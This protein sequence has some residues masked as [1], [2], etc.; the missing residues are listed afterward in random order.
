MMKNNQVA[1]K[2]HAL[3]GLLCPSNRPLQ[4]I[5]TVIKRILAR[6]QVTMGPLLH[7]LLDIAWALAYRVCARAS[8]TPTL[9]LH[10]YP[11]RK[12]I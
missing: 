5:K 6:P 10:T 1:G 2:Y 3:W 9:S 4:M 7:K 12:N 8:Y 11:K